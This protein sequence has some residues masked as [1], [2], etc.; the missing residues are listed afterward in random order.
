MPRKNGKSLTQ[1]QQKLVQLISENLGGTGGTKT[2]YEMMLAAG[3]EETT[4]RQQSSIL[5]GIRDELQPFVD[6]MT[7]HRENVLTE[8]VKKL[9]KAKYRELTDALDKLTKNIQLLSGGKTAND[10][11]KITWQK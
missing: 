4:A 8:M 9:P 1:R 11:L 6:A 5:V 10:E 3:Y 2:L 7:K